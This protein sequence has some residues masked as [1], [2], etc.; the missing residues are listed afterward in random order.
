MINSLIF[1]LIVFWRIHWSVFIAF[2]HQYWSFLHFMLF[3]L[4]NNRQSGSFLTIYTQ[5][6]MYL[7]FVTLDLFSSAWTCSHR[8]QCI[9]VHLYQILWSCLISFH[10]IW[11]LMK[12][13]L[14]LFH[15]WF[16]LLILS[17]CSSLCSTLIITFSNLQSLPCTEKE[18]FMMEVPMYQQCNSL[19]S[20]NLF[21]STFILTM[22]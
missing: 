19:N 4:T 15:H 14:F 8:C 7:T 11:I 13:I 12:C 17:W 21:Y 22:L 20:L 2:Y 16:F 18:E 1:Y 5:T 3:S 9:F 10:V 6:L